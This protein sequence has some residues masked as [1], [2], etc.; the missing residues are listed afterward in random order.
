MTTHL[1]DASNHMQL[2]S[3]ILLQSFNTSTITDVLKLCND[4]SLCV[5]TVRSTWD[6]VHTQL[7]STYERPQPG[8][9][10][11]CHSV[12]WWLSFAPRRNLRSVLL[13]TNCLYIC[14]RQRGGIVFFWLLFFFQ[15]QSKAPRGVCMDRIP[16]GRF[17]FMRFEQAIFKSPDSFATARQ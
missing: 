14:F 17:W 8:G 16:Q 11:H 15:Q 12:D 4:G 7:A 10:A 6:N 3:D 5:N 2:H 13:I 9:C 1:V